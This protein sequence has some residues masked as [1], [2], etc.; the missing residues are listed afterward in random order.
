MTVG[1]GWLIQWNKA[2]FK[3]ERWEDL[4]RL[5][6]DPRYHSDWYDTDDEGD[7]WYDNAGL[8]DSDCPTPPAPSFADLDNEVHPIFAAINF[9]GA[10]Y[11]VLLPALQLASLLIEAEPAL[12]FLHAMWFSRPKPVV[13]AEDQG[14]WH[15]AMF[16]PRK[17]LSARDRAMTRARLLTLT[18]ML[19]FY[20]SK[21]V[22][23]GEAHGSESHLT[24]ATPF[25]SGD[26]EGKIP[27]VLYSESIYREL[28]QLDA[29]DTPETCA[30]LHF[31]FAGLMVH[32]VAHAAYYAHW[33]H[34]GPAAEMP[35]ENSTM[36]ESGY[37][38][39]AQLFGGIVT[40]WTS[41]RSSEQILTEWPDSGVA[42][43]YL[44]HEYTV[45]VQYPRPDVEV[46]WFIS[47]CYVER[48]FT[49]KFWEEDMASL[50]AEALR[51]PK[52]WGYRRRIADTGT[53]QPL[54]PCR[55]DSA[56]YDGLPDGCY[57]DSHGYISPTDPEVESDGLGRLMRIDM[58]RVFPE[59][60]LSRF[61]QKLGTCVARCDGPRCG[62][63]HCC[64]E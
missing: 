42:R 32:E 3:C 34:Y 9:P 47:H 63:Y 7:E 19:R 41:A 1:D 11:N 17:V 55:G 24:L 51:I 23:G 10:D 12:E 15:W 37:E 28:C 22:G 52:G 62:P 2:G 60:C 59:V 58:P 33:G 5:C 35:F 46:S 38:L 56:L 8:D 50:D 44:H 18:H 20:P 64:Y 30:R 21:R 4:E 31:S 40:T 49:K 48:L 29:N 45:W 36:G 61:W 14:A 16:R 6:A 43:R 27:H 13:H 26:F 25:W 39:E 57:V 53:G 54:L